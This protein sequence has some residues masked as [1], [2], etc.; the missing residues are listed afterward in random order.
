MA[1]AD[2]MGYVVT[3]VMSES[4]TYLFAHTDLLEEFR[5]ALVPGALSDTSAAT[6]R[7]FFA[8]DA[9]V[10]ELFSLLFQEPPL[11]SHRSGTPNYVECANLYYVQYLMTTPPFA[12]GILASFLAPD[13]NCLARAALLRHL[14]A[15]KPLSAMNAE[16]LSRVLTALF[17]KA[18]IPT[19]FALYGIDAPAVF[20]GLL[21]QAGRE[22]IKELVLRICDELQPTPLSAWAS[23]PYRLLHQIFPFSTTLPTRGQL[24]KH[25]ST[26]ADYRF[27][28]M[29]YTC[30]FITDL[31]QEQRP[32]SVGLLLI[33]TLMTESDCAI[34]LVDG[35][36]ND[37]RTLPTRIACES[38]GMKIL[39]SLLQAHHCG[40][41]AQHQN[42]DGERYETCQGSLNAIWDVVAA[43]L[44]EILAYLRLPVP[45]TFTLKHVQILYLLYP[46]I[47]VGCIQLDVAL[48]AFDMVNVLL[49]L[50]ARFPRANILHSAICRLFITCLEDAPTLFGEELQS[51]RTASDPLRLSALL[52]TDRVI[53][54]C[55][56][57]NVACYKDIAMSYDEF[58]AQKPVAPDE[59]AG[60]WTAFASTQLEAIRQRWSNAPLEVSAVRKHK[61]SAFVEHGDV[62]ALLA[63]T[64]KAPTFADIDAPVRAAAEPPSTSTAPSFSPLNTEAVMRH[65]LAGATEK[66]SPRVAPLPSLHLS[67]SELHGS[68]HGRHRDV[69]HESPACKHHSSLSEPSSP[70]KDTPLHA[71]YNH[72][73]HAIIQG[74]G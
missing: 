63:L 68:D 57:R 41:V 42:L 60:K 53:D 6:L 3:T 48:M 38:Y 29:I 61:A 25:V 54:G 45:R 64:Q 28:L 39:N 69:D 33:E 27:P 49:D 19:F 40:C 66:G 1:E 10:A 34:A 15:Y 73:E 37:L 8:R 35:V 65:A 5:M 56:N 13:E 74:L 4:I 59:I 14:V 50:I 52:A 2:P 62:D 22:C 55:D 11:P 18:T 47:R 24:P 32:H 7:S 70:S 58:F 20:E 43:R 36:L 31:I 44:P 9:S 16:A 30:D 23:V 67:L 46:I 72:E 17:T 26:D 12:P 71:L 51:P 21:F